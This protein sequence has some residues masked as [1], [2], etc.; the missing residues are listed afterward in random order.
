MHAAVAPLSRRAPTKQ[1]ATMLVI[2]D[3]DNVAIVRRA[4]ISACG[5]SIELLR[6]QAVPRSTKM[7][8]WLVLAKSAA[9]DVMS[10]IMKTVPYGEIG[11]VTS[12]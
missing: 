10:V 12:D 3:A 5:E 2:L 7:R 4:V 9:T 6:T 11:P 8:V 1:M